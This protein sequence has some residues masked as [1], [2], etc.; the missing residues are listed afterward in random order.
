M[1]RLRKQVYRTKPRTDVLAERVAVEK[2]VLPTECDV[3]INWV[4]VEGREHT[5]VMDFAQAYKLLGSLHE[6]VMEKS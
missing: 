5:L 1:A 2:P 4:D 6:A 3:H